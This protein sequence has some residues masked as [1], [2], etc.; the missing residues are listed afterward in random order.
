M[1]N[2]TPNYLGAGQPSAGQ[3]CDGPLAW[4]ESLFGIFGGG[5]TPAYVGAGQPASSSSA[6][7]S[8]PVYRKAPPAPTPTPPDPLTRAD[9]AVPE[10]CTLP[11]PFGGGGY[12]IVIPRRE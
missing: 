9:D 1:V 6:V 2:T 5:G 11:D 8:S 3:S 7:S 10:S 12:A 4:L